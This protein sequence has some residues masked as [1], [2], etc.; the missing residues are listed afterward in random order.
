MA[1][2]ARRCP[3]GVFKEDVADMDEA[4]AGLMQLRPVT[5]HYRPAYDDSNT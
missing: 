5:F 1:S 4:S 3:H 2:L